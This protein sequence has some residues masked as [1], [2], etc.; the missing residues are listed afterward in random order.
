MERKE[1]LE[2]GVR[3]VDFQILPTGQVI[4]TSSVRDVPQGLILVKLFG[5]NL[6]SI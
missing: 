1:A 2:G 4:S 6:Y 3:E 5:V